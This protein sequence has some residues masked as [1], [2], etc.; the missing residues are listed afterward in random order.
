[1]EKRIIGAIFLILSAVMGFALAGMLIVGTDSVKDVDPTGILEDALVTCGAIIAVFSILTL[2]GAISAFTGKSWGLALV[3]GIFGLLTFGFSG[4]GSLFGLIGLI[5]VAISSSEFKGHEPPPQPYPPQ[6]YPPQGYPPQ[7]YPPQQPPP[8]YPP[9]Q[10]PPGQYPPQQ[11][12]M[13]Q[14]PMQQPPA[15]PPAEPPMQQ[16]PAAPEEPPETE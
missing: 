12:P 1:M 5:V 6:G 14:P 10:P 8:G 13:G 7:G 11:P 3:G 16:P 9:Q 15:A 4:L 2:L